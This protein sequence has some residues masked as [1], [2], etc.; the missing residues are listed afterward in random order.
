MIIGAVGN[1]LVITTSNL[2]VRMFAM[3]LIP[4][5]TLPPFQMILAWI[6]SSFS[7]PLVKRSVV[8]A[9][10]GMFGNAASIY[11]SYLYPDSQ[12]PKYVPAGIALACVCGACGTLALVIRVVLQ[13]ENRKLDRENG[14]GDGFRFIL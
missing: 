4:I 10:C 3:Y 6:T 2:G 9:I 14:P 13:R 5:G 8:V 12:G 11:G 1:I 7:R